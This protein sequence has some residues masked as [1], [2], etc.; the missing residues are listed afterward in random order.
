MLSEPQ[1][2]AKHPAIFCAEPSTHLVKPAPGVCAAL[3]RVFASLHSLLQLFL[4][5]FSFACAKSWYYRAAF[6]SFKCRRI[7]RVREYSFL[8]SVCDTFSRVAKS[9]PKPLSVF[10]KT[11]RCTA[12]LLELVVAVAFTHFRLCLF[13]H[14]FEEAFACKGYWEKTPA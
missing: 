9:D 2:R 1:Q 10:S 14:F 7:A 5:L 6:A 13:R 8:A 12:C 4:S 3:H 11:K